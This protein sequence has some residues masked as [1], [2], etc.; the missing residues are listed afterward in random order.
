MNIPL[1]L[2][3]VM[4]LRRLPGPLLP[5]TKLLAH[6]LK[7]GLQPVHLGH[8]T[9][10]HLPYYVLLDALLRLILLNVNCGLVFPI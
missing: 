8:Q 2:R 1:K 6:L 10:L 7:Q 3:R 4:T 9:R 5:L